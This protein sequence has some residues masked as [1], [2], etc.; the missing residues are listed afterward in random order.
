M[1]LINYL[2]CKIISVLFVNNYLMV[3]EYLRE[4]QNDIN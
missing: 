1:N 3:K 4:F 2:N